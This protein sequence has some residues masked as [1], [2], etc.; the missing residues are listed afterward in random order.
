MQHLSI[1]PKEGT[2][3]YNT[4]LAVGEKEGLSSARLEGRKL[5]E[6]HRQLVVTGS[7]RNVMNT[8]IESLEEDSDGQGLD[9]EEAIRSICNSEILSQ[10]Y[11]ES[12]L[13][14]GARLNS[15]KAQVLINIE[16]GSPYEEF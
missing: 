12:Y 9:D 1:A 14:S 7:H 15:E 4:S 13:D 6:D 5:D 16:D 3:P 8:E 11:E 10:K 2:R